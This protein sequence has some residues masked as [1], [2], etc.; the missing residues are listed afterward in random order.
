MLTEI[1]QKSFKLSF[2]HPG[3]ARAPADD[4]R[5]V[6]SNVVVVVVVLAQ[7][8]VKLALPRRGGCDG[9]KVDVGE[10]PRLR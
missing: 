5:S 8:V 9:R 4:E 6:A 2:L 3:D 7:V 1:G 10:A